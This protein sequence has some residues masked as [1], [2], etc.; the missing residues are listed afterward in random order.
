MKLTSFVDLFFEKPKLP[1]LDG[2]ARIF[3]NFDAA[4]IFCIL[5]IAEGMVLEMSSNS[6][7]VTSFT[8][9]ICAFAISLALLSK[10]KFLAQPESAVNVPCCQIL[11][12]CVELH[13]YVCINVLVFVFLFAYLY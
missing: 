3:I 2:K 11:I 4:V 8:A 6:R 9:C 10:E 1:P 5:R 13:L 12:V 7:A